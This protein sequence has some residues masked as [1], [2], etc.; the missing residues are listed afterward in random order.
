MTHLPVI[1]D[2]S[3]STGRTDIVRPL[4]RAC[5]AIGA[6]GIMVEVHPDPRTALCDAD[7]AL[8][9]DEA[10]KL[11][12]EIEPWIR[13]RAHAEATAAQTPHGTRAASRS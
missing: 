8:S 2:L 9:L 4:A 7:Q 13:V 3:H 1:V 10:S 12:D 5:V 11:I 6:E